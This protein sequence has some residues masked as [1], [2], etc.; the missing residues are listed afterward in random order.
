MRLWL[1]QEDRFRNA[2]IPLE[3]VGD[4]KKIKSTS[5]SKTKRRACLWILIVILIKIY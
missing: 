2:E 5:T 1:R 4:Q 3:F